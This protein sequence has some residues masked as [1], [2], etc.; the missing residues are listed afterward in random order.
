[1]AENPSAPADPTE[2]H[3]HHL[4]ETLGSVR[5]SASS[6]LTYLSF[7]YELEDLAKRQTQLGELQVA[8]K[9]LRARGYCW[10]PDVEHS[11]AQAMQLLPEAHRLAKLEVEQ[12][13]KDLV[14]RIENLARD[15]RVVSMRGGDP[16]RHESEIHALAG[17]RDGIGNAIRAVGE[18]ITNQIKP[19]TKLLE[20]TQ[21]AIRELHTVLDHFESASFK[22]AMEERPYAGV[23]ATWLDPPDGQPKKGLLL[24]T[25]LRIRFEQR[26]TVV[27]KKKFVFFTAESHEIK[28]L[29]LNEPIGNLSESL[30]STKGWILKDQF[31]T[32]SWAPRSAVRGKTSFQLGLG[33]AKLWDQK[34]EDLRVGNLA[35]YVGAGA[36]APPASPLLGVPLRWPESCS[37][38]NARLVVPVRGQTILICAYCTTEH[39]VTIGQTSAE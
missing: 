9:Q 16:L 8:A 7:S 39:P 26:E 19:I 12:A 11:L 13:A 34:I 35:P 17:E 10:R 20:E 21:Q 38:C 23:A 6:Q 15:A 37:S 33:D 36:A 14:G 18:R 5:E 24:L 31:L 28:Q 25:D 4:A 3:R 30:D 22:L 1:M 2:E 32:F 27:T 29:L